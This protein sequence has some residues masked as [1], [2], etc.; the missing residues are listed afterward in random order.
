MCLLSDKLKISD[1]FSDVIEAI[2]EK[3]EDTLWQ[4]MAGCIRCSTGTNQCSLIQGIP[5][6]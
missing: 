3:I 6:I 1:S 4:K 5:D 2:Y